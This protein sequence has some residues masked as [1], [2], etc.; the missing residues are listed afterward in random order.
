MGKRA[1]TANGDRIRTLRESKGWTP[2][3]LADACHLDV[4]TIRTAESGKGVDV[5]TLTSIADSLDV[6]VSEFIAT[7]QKRRRVTFTTTLDFDHIHEDEI[8]LFIGMLESM[9][10]KYNSEGQIAKALGDISLSET[11]S[12]EIVF[13]NKTKGSTFITLEMDDDDI[14]RILEVF[15]SE[16]NRDYSDSLAGWCSDRPLTES[17][18]RQKI[19]IALRKYT[20]TRKKTPKTTKSQILYPF[21]YRIGSKNLELYIILNHILRFT[22]Y[23]N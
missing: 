15:E 17:R 2:A 14:S 3:E 9:L 4:R 13:V 1:V 22:M 12:G 6:E 11:S 21:I 8:A 23:A 16:K 5:S 18:V 19:S 20:Y 7:K 10:H